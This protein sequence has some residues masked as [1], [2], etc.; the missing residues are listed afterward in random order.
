MVHPPPLGLEGESVLW[1]E[2]MHV[3]QDGALCRDMRLRDELG[4]R[5][6]EVWG[7]PE[8]ERGQRDWHI[9]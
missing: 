7:I 1:G 6:Q 9:A 2:G 5:R 8:V 3:P 4:E